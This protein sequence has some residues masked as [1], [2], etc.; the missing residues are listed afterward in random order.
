MKTKDFKHRPIYSQLFE[1]YLAGPNL[2]KE[3]DD[4]H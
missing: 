2:G 4:D 3:I 1:S